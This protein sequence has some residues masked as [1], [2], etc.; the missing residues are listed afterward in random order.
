MELAVGDESNRRAAFEAWVRKRQPMELHR[1]VAGVTICSV[2]PERMSQAQAIEYAA[3]AQKQEGLRICLVLDGRWS[4]W[5]T[6]DGRRYV[7]EARPDGLNSP[8][9]TIR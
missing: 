8:F 9:T 3:S 5:F 6:F 4:L 7:S 2:L 1:F